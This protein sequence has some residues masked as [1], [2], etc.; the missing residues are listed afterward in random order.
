MSESKTDGSF[1]IPSYDKV[2]FFRHPNYKPITKVMEPS[3]TSLEIVMTEVGNSAIDLPACA[4]IKLGGKWLGENIKLQTPI[5]AKS[6]H[7]FD[8]DYGYFTIS[9]KVEKRTAWISGV[10]GPMATPGIPHYEWILDAVE[11]SEHSYKGMG[12]FSDMRGKSKDGTYWR[13]I[14]M[15]GEAIEYS[16]LTL[17]E[18]EYF[19]KIIGNACK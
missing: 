19:D 13:Y 12:L 1:S 14:G 10:Y 17:K 4:S 15:F 2:I 5:G 3:V 18:A 7:G 6:K 16:G 9:K 8:T 11:F